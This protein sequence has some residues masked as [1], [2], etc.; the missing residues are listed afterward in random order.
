MNANE[1]SR[2]VVDAA[3]KV[4]SALGPG[5]LESVYET[6]LA[7]ELETRGIRIERQLALPV[8]Y[9]ETVVEAGLRIDLLVEQCL[10]LEIKAVESLLAIRSAQLLTYLKFGNHPLGLFPNFNVVRMK[11]G[12]KRLANGLHE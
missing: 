2:A 11:D 7:H 3:I 12:I 9:G 6:C 4:H 5:L 1:A 8:R 10:V